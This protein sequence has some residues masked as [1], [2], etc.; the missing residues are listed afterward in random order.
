VT[1]FEDSRLNRADENSLTIKD[2]TEIV[3]ESM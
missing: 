3:A 2:V 1:M